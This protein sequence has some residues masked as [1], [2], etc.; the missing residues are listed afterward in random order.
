MFAFYL[1]Y[2]LLS[3]EPSSTRNLYKHPEM[4][5]TFY[6]HRSP[7][8]QGKPEDKTMRGLAAGYP[9]SFL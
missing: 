4:Y 2:G 6:M 5:A 9:L 3:S 8:L 1:L 7:N